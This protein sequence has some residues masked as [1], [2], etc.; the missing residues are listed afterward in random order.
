MPYAG[1]KGH[2]TL[3]RVALDF[4]RPIVARYGV[5]LAAGTFGGHGDVAYAPEV[6]IVDLEEVQV[7]GLKAGYAY[8]RCTGR[9]V[10]E[11]AR[12]TT[13]AAAEVANKP[14]VL[15]KARRIGASGATVGFVNEEAQPGYRV[16]LAPPIFSSRISATSGPREPPPPGY[17]AA[18]WAAASPR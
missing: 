5:T 11:A 8:R 10:K 3:E 16:F 4:F 12:T 2:I 1:V 17:A 14:G 6:K 7:D 15:L 18:S 9:P 13:A